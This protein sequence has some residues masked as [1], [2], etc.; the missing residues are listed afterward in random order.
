MVPGDT[1]ARGAPLGTKNVDLSEIL[2]KWRRRRS[3]ARAGTAQATRA[4]RQT[5]ERSRWLRLGKALTNAELGMSRL[6]ETIE[7]VAVK[8]P[9]AR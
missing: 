9:L 8:P 2:W 3:P 5:I 1:R 6:G 4:L 7:V